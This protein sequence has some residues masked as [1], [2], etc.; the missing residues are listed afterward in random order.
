[1]PPDAGGAGEAR[2]GRREE[3]SVDCVNGGMSLAHLFFLGA[4]DFIGHIGY[5]T[6]RQ[7]SKRRM[8]RRL[9]SSER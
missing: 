1:M 8:S 2:V 7:R 4:I 6:R 9:W 3:V 5:N